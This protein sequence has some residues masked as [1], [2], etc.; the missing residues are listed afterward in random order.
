[1]RRGHGSS[2]R[3]WQRATPFTATGIP[4]TPTSP[5]AA[6][7][8]RKRR[9]ASMP[10]NWPRTVMRSAPRRSLTCCRPNAT[11]TTRMWPGSSP[12]PTSPMPERSY[13]LPQGA[14]R[15]PAPTRQRNE[16][17]P[18][19]AT[20]SGLHSGHSFVLDGLSFLSLGGLWPLGQP[21][22]VLLLTGG[23]WNLF[24]RV[25]DALVVKLDVIH[26]RSGQVSPTE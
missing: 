23:V 17:G 25:N 10:P 12:T 22:L 2:G 18:W 8:A 6:R 4:C 20:A 7:R 19:A 14:T 3:G 15:S 21:L 13:D 24:R 16:Q 9:P 1:M 5:T 11:P 26:V